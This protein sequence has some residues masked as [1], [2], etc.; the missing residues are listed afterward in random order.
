MPTLS[1]NDAPN[2]ID[3]LS[4]SQ[5]IK[6]IAEVINN[7]TPPKGIGINGYWGTG[8]TSALLQLHRE[9]TG[10]LP[11][12]N[13]R[14]KNLQV[15]TVWFEAWRYQ[16]EPV[17]I[18]S[19]LHEIRTRIRLWNRFLGK[20][21]KLMGVVLQGVFTAFDETIKVAS[22][23]LLQNTISGLNKAGEQWERNHYET[24]LQGQH[25]SDLL[26]EAIEKALGSNSRNNRKL[27]IFIDDLDRCTPEVALKLLEGI[28]IYLNL[29]NCVVV[30]G[31]DQRQIEQALVK[32]LDLKGD[33]N[34]HQAR[35]Y[36][37]KICQD[38]YHLPLPDKDAKKAYLLKLLEG[39]KIGNDDNEH[40]QHLATVLSNYDC[41]PA[42]PRKIKALANRLA[43][44][45]RANIL[46]GDL[47]LIESTGV[48]REYAL[49]ISMTIIYT[50]HR[51]L[52]EQLEKDSKYINT[53]IMFA[54]DPSKVDKDLF[55][56]MGGIKPSLAAD[57]ALPTNPSDSNIFRLHQLFRDLE[58]I[59]E[60]EITIFLGK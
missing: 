49:L 1:H 9:L 3:S 12:D 44:M 59:T 50:F 40:R 25:I 51:Q 39:L 16:N 5:F 19:L 2:D 24:P 36:L 56:P 33:N 43:V 52:N 45:L 8:K 31:M 11:T 6:E 20:S 48:R 21:K 60:S 58:S 7:S 18:I 54:Q 23:G 34:G 57:K 27:V 37:E 13:K 55:E 4:Q 30:F 29:K 26:E 46:T 28:K 10:I 38:I 15:T 32:A 17:P 41:L 42:N 14:P 53:V 35:E 47:T 22:A